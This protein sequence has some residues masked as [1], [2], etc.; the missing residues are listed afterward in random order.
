MSQPAPYACHVFICVNDRQGQSKS[1]ADGGSPDIRLQLKARLAEKFAGSQVRVSQSRCLGL[2]G[3]G[4]NVL[5]YPQN[6]WYSAVSM[7]DVERIASDIEQ[8]LATPQ[9]T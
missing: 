9:G 1:C 7:G 8:L 4:P 3:E 5:I 2:C 6:L